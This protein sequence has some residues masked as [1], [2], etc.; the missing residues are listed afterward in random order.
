MSAA[1]A[2]SDPHVGI[3][4]RMQYSYHRQP[5]PEGPTWTSS[6]E[7][8]VAGTPP[9][10]GATKCSLPALSTEIEGRRLVRAGRPGESHPGLPQNCLC[11]IPHNRIYVP[12]TVMLQTGPAVRD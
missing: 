11:G 5:R 8:R 4:A 1:P 6:I 2:Y 7:L 3:V 12:R 10:V 9:M